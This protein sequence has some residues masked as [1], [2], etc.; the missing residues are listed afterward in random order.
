MH[1]DSTA[2]LHVDSRGDVMLFVNDGVGLDFGQGPWTSAGAKATNFALRFASDGSTIS[3]WPV[4]NESCIG[5]GVPPLAFDRGD[6]LLVTKYD[7]PVV[8]R[9]SPSGAPLATMPVEMSRPFQTG[10]GIWDI[11]VTSDGGFILTG[12][13]SDP[14]A[15]GSTSLEARD[16]GAHGTHREDLFMARF[17]EDGSPRFAL[18]L[19]SRST[20]CTSAYA[21]SEHDGQTSVVMGAG[22]EVERFDETGG[23]LP[24][25]PT[26]PGAPTFSGAPAWPPDPSGDFLLRTGDTWVR[27]SSERLPR[28]YLSELGALGWPHVAFS[29]STTYIA[30]TQYGSY[31]IEDTDLGTTEAPRAVLLAVDGT[32]HVAWYHF[33]SRASH[34]DEVLG[35]G[36]DSKG[37]IVTLTARHTPPFV[38]SSPVEDLLL[39]RIDP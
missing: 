23:S 31:R 18:V 37:G 5:C 16:L 38:S 32:G 21:V 13:F 11:V 1:G 39:E 15:F 19:G 30:G 7:T 25:P 34:A 36:V 3:G 17:A 12:C 33:P 6:W 2:A 4:P 27:F 14:L 28:W 29:G 20:G 35:I 22:T 9:F 26:W 10:E 24:P 8:R